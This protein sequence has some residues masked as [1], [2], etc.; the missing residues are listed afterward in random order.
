MDT[1]DE[2]RSARIGFRVRP[3]L[4]AELE[5]LAKQDRRT[6]ASYLEIALEAHV[7]A[8]RKEGKRR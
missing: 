3:S 2:Q 1:D 7:E 6:L 4:K 8:K 5:R